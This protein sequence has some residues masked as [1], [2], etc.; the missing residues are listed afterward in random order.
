MVFQ[1]E[2][3]LRYGAVND[4]DTIIYCGKVNIFAVG[5]AS[6]L[7]QISFLTLISKA[8]VNLK[9][10]KTVDIDLVHPA[11]INELKKAIVNNS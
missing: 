5:L 3:W 10:L 9:D 11:C 2:P 4:Q 7:N 6:I 8:R 1:N